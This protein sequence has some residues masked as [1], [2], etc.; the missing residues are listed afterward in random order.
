MP[1]AVGAQALEHVVDAVYLEIPGQGHDG[2]L[3][4]LQAEGAATALAIEV[5]MHV[6]DG[7]VVLAAV[8]VRTAHGIFEHPRAVVD[9]MDEVVGQEQGDGAVDGRFVH[10]VQLVFKALQR[11]GIVMAHHGAQQQDAQRRG[12]HVVLLQPLDIFRFVSHF[13]FNF[14]YPGFCALP[15]ALSVSL[16]MGNTRV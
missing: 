4:R 2:H 12:L 3:G 1:Q 14:Q 7:A 13:T 11:E 8:A 15:Q 6:V 5:G 16:G 9:G 10:R